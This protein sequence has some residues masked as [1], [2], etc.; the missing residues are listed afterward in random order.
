MTR[1]VC[2]ILKRNMP[3]WVATLQRA[4][5]R[6]SKDAEQS[7]LTP[8]PSTGHAQTKR[9]RLLTPHLPPTV[10]LI[11]AA[12]LCSPAR[13]HEPLF[14]LGPETIYEG[15]IGI[16]AELE[17]EDAKGERLTV[18]NYEILYGLRENL[19][20]TLK[21]PHILAR[22][23]GGRTERGLGD[24]EFRAKYRFFKKDTLG[25][26]NK[27]SG[28]F[29]I[30]VPT[31]D[32]DALPPLGTGTVDLLFGATYGYESRTWY[33]FA[34]TRYRLRTQNDGR[35]L[36]DRLF[37]DAAAGYRPWRRE[38]FEWDLVVLAEV[39]AEF[40]FKDELRGV[41]LPDTGGNTVWVGPTA[42]LSYR[43]VMFK[44]G[45]QFPLYEDLN[46]KQG[47]SNVR[48]VVSAEYHF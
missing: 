47:S 16:E 7:S 23:E 10:L 34:T 1:N 39:N 30:K 38:Y 19:S 6:S 46:G 36:G 32:E 33:G 26:Q 22:T 40:E 29:G 5:A 21:V 24:I 37:L 2:S 8:H 18:I 43:N 25:A 3:R 17:F 13:A 15:G 41:R 31:G 14:S 11:L 28:I 4:P 20:L 48:A 12:L 35:D 44:G 9:R 27:V 45:I 42:L